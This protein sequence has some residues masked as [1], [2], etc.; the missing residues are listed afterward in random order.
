MFLGSHGI[1]QFTYFLVPTFQVPIPRIPSKAAL[2]I[3]D[4]IKM[5]P[6]LGN[7]K[8][9]SRQSSVSSNSSPIDLSIP[10]NSE[11]TQIMKIKSQKRIKKEA[12]IKEEKDSDSTV[13]LKHASLLAA[14]E[15]KFVNKDAISTYAKEM[16]TKESNVNNVND[17]LAKHFVPVQHIL[18]K[19]RVVNKTEDSEHVD[20]HI[21]NEIDVDDKAVRIEGAVRH[22]GPI[23]PDSKKSNKVATKTGHE[24]MVTNATEMVNKMEKMNGA[25]TELKSQ[26]LLASQSLLTAQ[27]F[28]LSQ[29]VL[30]SQPQLLTDFSDLLKSMSGSLKSFDV[31]DLVKQLIP[32]QGMQLNSNVSALARSLSV[33]SEHSFAS[34]KVDQHLKVEKQKYEKGLDMKPPRAVE[35]RYSNVEGIVKLNNDSNDDD[36]V[37]LTTKTAMDEVLAMQTKVSNNSTVTVGR[38]NEKDLAENVSDND[39]DDLNESMDDGDEEDHEH[40]EDGANLV[41]DEEERGESTSDINKVSK[42]VDKSKAENG[43][44]DRISDIVVADG[45]IKKHKM[46]GEIK[47]TGIKKAKLNETSEDRVPPVPGSNTQNANL[48][49]TNSDNFSPLVTKLDSKKVNLSSPNVTNLLPVTTIAGDKLKQGKRHTLFYKDAGGSKTVRILMDDS[50][51]SSLVVQQMIQASQ[52]MN[53]NSTEGNNPMSPN[54][55][56][57]RDTSIQNSETMSTNRNPLISVQSTL[58]MIALQKGLA[59]SSFQN[60]GTDSSKPYTVKAVTS[61][62][63]KHSSNAMRLPI[64]LGSYTVPVVSTCMSTLGNNIATS[65]V[66]LTPGSYQNINVQSLKLPL[67]CVNASSV[68]NLLTVLAREKGAESAKSIYSNEAHSQIASKNI[69][70]IVS[71]SS[72]LRKANGN[73]VL[74]KGSAKVPDTFPTHHITDMKNRQ[75]K[76]VPLASEGT[77][78]KVNP[79]IKNKLSKALNSSQRKLTTAHSL[80]ELKGLRKTEGLSEHFGTG[81]ETR[82]QL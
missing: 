81:T 50:E 33:S 23:V 15:G 44:V 52:K 57:L 38:L 70:P 48:S 56:V 53:V 51:Q 11:P 22:N 28:L 61:E 32:P 59:V 25:S 26:P 6:A 18:K 20:Q 46:K 49:S 78:T 37:D 16:N 36:D 69:Y 29:Q 21:D 19:E 80:D 2:T 67:P 17:N 1:H 58:P 54:V 4:N 7:F 63:P 77:L 64:K 60:V 68:Q 35:S 82:Q 71:N 42:K 41:I 39:V 9:F 43:G 76:P 73:K 45:F 74:K 47:D 55:S 79:D 34:I 31:L 66:T 8:S 30:A 14:L 12:K 24:Q 27:Q 10:R 5:R 72:D 62:I 65:Q 40:E 3:G 75:S 13:K